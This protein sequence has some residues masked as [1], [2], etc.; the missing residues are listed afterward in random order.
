MAKYLNRYSEKVSDGG[1]EGNSDLK[2]VNFGRISSHG[3]CFWDNG[4]GSNCPTRKT[5]KDSKRKRNSRRGLQGRII[6][7]LYQVSD[8]RVISNSELKRRNDGR[9]SSHGIC[10]WDGC[11][12]S[13]DRESDVKVKKIIHCSKTLSHGGVI[14]NSE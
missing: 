12:S 5:Y 7:C 14:Q 13:C 4:S 3:V 8:C 11:N 10:F 9:I 2:G 6:H 1:A